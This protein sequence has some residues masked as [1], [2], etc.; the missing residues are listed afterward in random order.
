LSYNWSFHPARI[1]VMGC[2]LATAGTTVGVTATVEEVAHCRAIPQRAERLNC[3]NS[4]KQSP[5]AKT[6]TPSAKQDASVSKAKDAVSAATAKEAAEAK[7][8]ANAQRAAPPKTN[9][10]GPAD[11]NRSDPVTTS[12]VDRFSAARNQPLCETPDALAAMILAGLLT[13]NP[14]TAATPGCQI[15]PDDATLSPVGRSP[16]FFPFMR[17]VKVKVASPALPQLT[18]GFTI[19]I[20][21]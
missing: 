8:P 1:V 6:Q 3:F 16:S 7:T 19:E 4:L 15:I 2:V 20:D 11:T 21:R 10:A 18:S 12:S 17:I 14:E 9:G 13:T 5:R